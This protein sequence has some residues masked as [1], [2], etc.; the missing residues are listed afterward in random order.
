MVVLRPNASSTKHEV[1][2]LDAPTSLKLF[3]FTTN[4]ELKL[5]YKFRIIIDGIVLSTFSSV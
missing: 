4:L 1:A 5:Y 2:Q 3:P